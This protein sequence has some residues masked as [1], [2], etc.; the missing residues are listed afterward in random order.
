MSHELDTT[1]NR[2]NMAY[3][4]EKPWHGLGQELTY[5]A[6]I[7]TWKQEAGMSW[8]VQSSPLTYQAEDQTLTFP[9]RRVLYRSDNH[10]A[11]G[12]VSNNYKVVHPGQALEF[13]RD[14]V[15][16]HG[17]QLETAGCLFGGRKYW[18][19]A[20]ISE[21]FRIMGEDAVKPYLLLA[22]SCDGSMSTVAD[23]TT[24]RVVCNNTLRMSIGANG[25]NAKVKVPHHAA[26]DPDGVK[27]QLGL[28]GGA[29]DNFTQE[30]ARLAS[31]KLDRGLAI[32]IVADELKAEWLRKDGSPMTTDEMF[33]GSTVLR[34]IIKLYD[35]EAMGASFKSSRGTGWGLVNAV[36][37]FCD[38]E[39]GAKREDRS[40][41][42]E[43]AHLTDRAAFKT[44]VANRILQFV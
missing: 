34:R 28:I 30:A 22:T 32:Q 38:H 7:D 3:V 6:S 20:K 18:A 23:L 35:G 12:V 44:R 31:F 16:A 36:T 4:G 21:G 17:F 2:N 10:A 42:F 8:S 39:A 43:R 27:R 9:D 33:D 24:V 26:F 11:L 1:N 13:F 41:A 5:D 19:L 37:E 14:L 25:A 15:D 40:R 29:W